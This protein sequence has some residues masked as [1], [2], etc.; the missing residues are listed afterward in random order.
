MRLPVTDLSGLDEAQQRTRV[1]E[2]MKREDEQPFD[3]SQGPL[4]RASV[5]KLAP[6][7]HILLRTMHHIVSDGWSEGVFNRELTLLYE[8][9]T[10]ERKTRCDPCLVQ[11]ADFALWQRN[12]MD[13]GALAHGLAYWLKQLD[14]IPERLELPTDRSAVQT[15][16]AGICFARW[17]KEQALALKHLGR[18]NKVTLYMTLVGAFGALL[19]RYSGQDDIVVGSPI[20]NRRETQ[21]EEMIG[22]FVNSLVIRMQFAK[23]F[24]RFFSR[25][26]R[27]TLEAYQ[28]QD[29]PFERLVEELSPER[30]L[31]TT[32]VYQVVFAL[33][34]APWKPQ[35]SADTYPRTGGLG[36]GKGSD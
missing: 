31:N 8:A 32:P 20:A 7:E 16:Q 22:F 33:Q 26:R 12:W 25:V 9:Y 4:I 28:A 23:G 18:R 24:S 34:N 10:R 5:L 21:L 35:Q 15:F 1:Q 14:G 6:Q 11:Y 27:T 2:A 13:E 3:L 30:S 36:R 29:V 19:S 17:P